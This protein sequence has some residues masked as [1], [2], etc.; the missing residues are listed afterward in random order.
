MDADTFVVLV[1]DGEGDLEPI[2]RR[3]RPFG[4]NNPIFFTR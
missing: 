3:R 2:Y 4:V 1:A